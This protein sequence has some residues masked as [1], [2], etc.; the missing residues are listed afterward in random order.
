MRKSH[1][2]LVGGWAVFTILGFEVYRWF[3]ILAGFWIYIGTLGT[4]PDQEQI[5]RYCLY[6]KC[7]KHNRGTE[8]CPNE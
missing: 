6:S 8:P 3:H 7:K 2:I 4:Y 1:V 5:I